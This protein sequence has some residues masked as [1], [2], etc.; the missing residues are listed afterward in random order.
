MKVNHFIIILTAIYI[1]ISLALKIKM[2]VFIAETYESLSRQAANVVK[3]LVQSLNNPLICTASGDSPAGLYK[4]IVSLVNK[5]ELDVS[6]WNF[7]S[8]DEWI[9]MNGSDE[10][11]CR[12][13]LDRQLFHPLQVTSNRLGF[14][15]GKAV[16]LQKECDKVEDFIQEHN[17]I[18]IAIL[19][20][21]MN[22]HVGLNE[23]GVSPELRSHVMEVHPVTKKT[24]QKYFNE[25]KELN[26][27]ITL[28]L[29]TI[30]EAKNIILLVSGKHKAGIVKRII[31]E[32][33]SEE[34]PASILRNHKSLKICLDK[35]AA[36]LLN[37]FRAA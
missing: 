16:D 18:D 21:G 7:V 27:G 19:G 22:G 34:L 29:A 20:L 13:Y 11:S 33:I 32:D 35:E 36:S 8:L 14:F 30:L 10:G 26:K 6:T 37:S 5:N 15:D 17:G 24:G 4:E 3:E 28:G 25:S 1:N 12:F 31:E 2:E 9:G 23:P